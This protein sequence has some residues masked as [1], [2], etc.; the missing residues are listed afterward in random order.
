MIKI[1]VGTQ[2]NGMKSINIGSSMNIDYKALADGDVGGDV[3]TAFS[4]MKAETVSTFPEVMVTYIQI[5]YKVSV[6]ASKALED[7][8]PSNV[9]VPKWV[10]SKLTTTGINVNDPQVSELLDVLVPTHAQS[11]KDMGKVEVPKYP[12]LKRTTH[13]TKARLMRSEGRV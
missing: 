3:E 9:G 4:T 6:A 12:Y 7:A 2:L 8:L 10:N 1:T 13:L 5:G 11:I